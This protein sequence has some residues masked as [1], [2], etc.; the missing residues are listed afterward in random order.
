MIVLEHIEQ[1][2][3]L[4]Q[5]RRLQFF[6][7]CKSASVS[8]SFQDK[9]ILT[10]NYI[11]SADG[12]ITL[13]DIDMLLLPYFTDKLTIRISIRIADLS[14]TKQINLFIVFCTADYDGSALDYIRQHFLSSSTGAKETTLHNT[15]LLSAIL[16]VESDCIANISYWKDNQISTIT[17][18]ITSISVKFNVVTIN[19]SPSLFVDA[20]AELLSYEISLGNRRQKYIL[21]SRDAPSPQLQFRNSFGVFETFSCYGTLSI[22]PT[23][24]RGGGYI[25]NLLTHYK[26][27]E[28]RIHKANSGP[29]SES[30]LTLADELLRSTEV[31]DLES[32]KRI[33]ITDSES[34]RNNEIDNLPVV[35]FEYKY[36]QR[37]HNILSPAASPIFSPTFNYVYD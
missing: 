15:E 18:T 23:F 22:E 13:H 10:E 36:A 34:K 25:N 30:M 11:T 12:S 35:T 7:D 37:N 26:I 14:D 16:D 24:N 3:F 29:L 2:I 9:D 17:K 6:T 21:I 28:E 32:K 20:D 4:S 31:Y 8:I 1:Y 33:I 27:D 5:L 19:V